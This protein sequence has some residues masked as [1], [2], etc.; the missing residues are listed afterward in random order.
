MYESSMYESRYLRLLLAAAIVAFLSAPA[1]LAKP[2]G[3]K[4][5]PGDSPPN[6]SAGLS[7]SISAGITIG[8]AR[9]IASRYELTGAKPLPP[10]IRKNLARGKPL[11]PGIARQQLPGGFVDQLPRHDGYQWQRAGADLVLVASGSLVIN[12]ILEGVFD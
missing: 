5:K 11:P 7:A 1:A 12:D 6:V 9:Q 3:D 8:D 2:P 10:G 4:G